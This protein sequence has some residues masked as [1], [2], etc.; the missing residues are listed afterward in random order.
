[1]VFKIYNNTELRQMRKDEYYLGGK[2]LSTY[3]D[4]DYI[5]ING[6][7]YQSVN[8]KAVDEIVDLD[9][10]FSEICD[11]NNLNS[12]CIGNGWY[13]NIYSIDF[14]NF[15][16]TVYYK[17][18][19]E[20]LSDSLRNNFGFYS[21]NAY[22]NTFMTLINISDEYKNGI[23]SD[24]YTTKSYGERIQDIKTLSIPIMVERYAGGNQLYISVPIKYL[25]QQDFTN[26]YSNGTRAIQK[27]FFKNIFS[28]KTI[29]YGCIPD[30]IFNRKL[31]KK[32]LLDSM[33][34][35]YN[36]KIKAYSMNPR[37]NN[38]NTRI[39][40]TINKNILI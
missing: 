22:I 15:K 1:M 24:F 32:E 19:D 12:D 20:F 37:G 38:R 11:N 18:G 5:N 23:I 31:N 4:H 17:N 33:I 30:I 35:I 13:R 2:Y 36:A 39:L 16:K 29:F 8:A 25:I 9:K 28:D 26:P 6:I 10:E 40:Q 34:K 14:L 27:L 7:K 3:F 21:E